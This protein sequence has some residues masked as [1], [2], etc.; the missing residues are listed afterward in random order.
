[1]SRKLTVKIDILK[2]YLE[3]Y[4]RDI[5]KDEGTSSDYVR[6]YHIGKFDGI[7][8]ALDLLTSYR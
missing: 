8:T 6:G 5:V 7:K 3:M 4:R 2:E 1:M